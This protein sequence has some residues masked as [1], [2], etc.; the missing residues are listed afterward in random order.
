MF[1]DKTFD[2]NYNLTARTSTGL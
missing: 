1:S 2:N